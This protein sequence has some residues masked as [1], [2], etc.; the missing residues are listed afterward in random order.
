MR[1][2]VLF[3]YPGTR[4][5]AYMAGVGIIVPGQVLSAAGSTAHIYA[6]LC[7]INK[8]RQTFYRPG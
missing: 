7:S 6:Q 2:F 1:T 4:L 3:A 5:L 8:W